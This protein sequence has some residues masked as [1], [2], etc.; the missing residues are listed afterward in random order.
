MRSIVALALLALAPAAHANVRNPAV[1]LFAAAR[2]INEA[3]QQQHAEA[4][5]HATQVA[6]AVSAIYAGQAAQPG[7]FRPALPRAAAQA[8]RSQPIIF[9]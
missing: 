2:Q 8:M 4:H 3:H 9:R 5:G 6:A 1:D 7:W